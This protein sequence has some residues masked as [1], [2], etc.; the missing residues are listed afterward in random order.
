M[1]EEKNLIQFKLLFLTKN[2][3]QNENTKKNFKMF[4]K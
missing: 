2:H 3:F 4:L 1:Y